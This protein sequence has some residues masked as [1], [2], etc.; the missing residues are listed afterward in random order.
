MT[1]DRLEGPQN[2][3]AVSILIVDDNAATCLTLKKLLSDPGYQLIF[4]QDGLT[5]IG[6]AQK[7][8]PDLV[9]L[10]ALMPGMDGLQVCREL[11]KD[12]DL[13]DVPIIMMTPPNDRRLRLACIEAGADEFVT[14]P[15]DLSEL[16]ARV[17]M[18]ARMNRYRRLLAE[19]AK[20]E[21][22]IELS[23]DGIL[24]VDVE[25]VIRMAN[26]TFARMVQA[27]SV[28]DV[29]G[30]K[31]LSYVYL[32][33]VEQLATAFVNLLSNSSPEVRLEVDL[34]R[35]DETLLPV[36]INAGYFVWNGYPTV[37][38]ILRDITE[39]RRAAEQLRRAHVELR[40]AYDATIEGW[41]RALELRDQETQGHTLRVTELTVRLAREMGI[42]DKEALAH[43]RRGALLH[44]I[45]K[46]GIPD[47][48]LLKPGPLTEEEQEIMK[49]HPVYAYE[50]LSPIEYLRPALDIPYCH[51][52]R[53][54]GSGYPR[55]LKGEE[56]PLAA[57]IFAVV[58]V[59]DALCS[60]R[61]YRNG[62]SREEALNYIRAQAG[63][64]FDPRVV[65]AFVRL[66]EQEDPLLQT[67]EELT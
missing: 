18:A 17:R 54:D 20:F 63:R 42:E 43:I 13:S 39:R 61:P 52:E 56:I 25:G 67:S 55:G 28:A 58:D 65:E 9:L 62:L 22:L 3:V 57:R 15:F 31:L 38:V 44:D 37:Q 53:W 29:T 45:G 64:L 51:H 33:H 6:K 35:R 21:R 47:S 46:M 5:A 10:D 2:N 30:E 16:Q 26:L 14:K 40:M 27:N 4:A 11:R 8:K 34:I 36:E 1:T 7:L 48:I 12:P 32:P 60:D 19:R 23:P 50:M 49:K 24:I 66:M 59:W 41:S